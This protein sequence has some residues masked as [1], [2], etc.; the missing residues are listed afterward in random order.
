[1][2]DFEVIHR[3]RESDA[4]F[5]RHLYEIRKNGRKVAEFSH[6]YRNEDRAIRRSSLDRWENFE[7]ILEG[8]GPQ[9]LRVSAIGMVILTKY[10]AT[11]SKV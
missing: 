9:P 10:L 1:M 3:G 7:S 2:S 5:A 11:K 6:S 8:G 4:A